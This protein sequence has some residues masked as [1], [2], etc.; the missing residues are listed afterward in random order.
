MLDTS[1][2]SILF[3]T[4]GAFEPSFPVISLHLKSLSDTN[5]LMQSPKGPQPKIL[6]EPEK[7]V[8][9]IMT[10]NADI[11]VRDGTTGTFICSL[12]MQPRKESPAISMYII[13]KHLRKLGL[14]FYS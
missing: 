12:P 8:M 5:S 3:L 1:T 7:Q 9:F 6:N 14:I 2:S 11:I 13:G 4:D 10:R